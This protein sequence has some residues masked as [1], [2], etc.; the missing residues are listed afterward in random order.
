MSTRSAARK[1]IVV[2]RTA[3]T[4]GPAAGATRGEGECG[5]GREGHPHAS[6]RPGLRPPLVEEQDEHHRHHGE[7]LHEDQQRVDEVG[8][9]EA[10]GAEADAEG[11]QVDREDG[12]RGPH[13][14]RDE[15]VGQVAAVAHVDRAGPRGRG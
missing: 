8:V 2:A 15:A 6:S 4:S 5:E 3:R 13:P 14:E 12:E 10:H 11:D 1:S 7:G 9:G